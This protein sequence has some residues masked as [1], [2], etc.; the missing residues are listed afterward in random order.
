M[1]IPRSNELDLLRLVLSTSVVFQHSALAGVET[2]LPWIERIPAVP[3]FILLSGLLV[4]ESYFNSTSLSIYIKKRIRR[5]VPGYL[6]IVLLGGALLWLTGSALSL[7]GSGSIK[8]LTS[9]YFFNSIFLNF[10]HPCVF[11]TASFSN[12]KFCAVNGSLW[13]IKFELAF[14]LILPAILVALHK[15]PKGLS[16][17]ASLLLLY[18]T[19]LTESIYIQIVAC[20]FAGVLLSVSR[21]FWIPAIAK[22]KVTP[23]FR[24]ALLL[25]TAAIS[26]SFLPLPIAVIA[27]LA[28]SFVGTK[29]DSIGLNVLK[30]GDLSYG[31]YLI[32]YPLIQSARFTGVAT[33][34]PDVLFAPAFTA[35]SALLA[36]PLYW[37]VEKRFLPA[38]SHYNQSME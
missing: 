6:A 10:L 19:V 25:T 3:L 8:Q 38:S 20:F 22:A 17:T 23:R 14:Y 13:T 2:H 11:D 21:K 7:P 34:I 18:G 4:S 35:M 33:F 32:H 28:A 27:L 1:R 9:Y 12:V 5:I 16:L 36:I 30:Y 15:L 37:H 29:D 26:G 24:I 31:I